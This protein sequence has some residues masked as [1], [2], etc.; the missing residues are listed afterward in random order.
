M[1]IQGCFEKI[2]HYAQVGW[3]A[4]GWAFDT[5]TAEAVRLVLVSDGQPVQAVVADRFRCDLRDAGFGQGSCAFELKLPE[6]LI[7][8]RPHHLEIYIVDENRPLPKSFAEPFFPAILQGKLEFLAE[9]E[10]RGWAVSALA[11]ARPPILDVLIDDQWVA[12]IACDQSR[13]DI[14]AQT[15]W[16]VGGGF[17]FYIPPEYHDDHQHTL[18]FRFANGGDIID[19]GQRSFNLPQRLQT[20]RQLFLHHAMEKS[21]RER[22]RLAQLLRREPRHWLRDQER[23]ASWRVMHETTL[24]VKITGIPRQGLQTLVSV[25][26]VDVSETAAV[27]SHWLAGSNADVVVFCGPYDR[28]HPG[29][30]RLLAARFDDPSIDA[31]TFDADT[32]MADGVHSAPHFKPAWDPD[33]HLAKNY[34]G[35]ACA[36]RRSALRDVVDAHGFDRPRGKAL[37]WA[38]RLLDTTLLEIDPSRVVHMPFVLF[39]QGIQH[40]FRL[41]LRAR[42]ARLTR[43][44]ATRNVDATVTRL[45]GGITHV[46]RYLPTPP[47]V[48][49]IIPT[50][51]RVDLLETCVSSL[52][53]QTQYPHFQILIVDNQ[54]ERPETRDYLEAVSAHDQVSVTSWPHAFNYAGLH[55]AV[56]AEIET[57]FIGL[58]NNDIEVIEGAWLSEMMSHAIRSEVAAVGAK[59]LFPEGLIQHGGVVIGQHGIADNAQRAFAKDEAGY[60]DSL[61][62]PQ[63]V[64]A[65][66]AACLICRRAD[67]LAVGGM[68]AENLPISF[69]DVDFCLK[70]KAQGKKIIWT[71][72]ATLIHHESATRGD[73]TTPAH[74]RREKREA[75]FLKKKWDTQNFDD[76]YYSPNLSRDLQT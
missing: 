9:A 43:H 34:V 68:D 15:S 66:T 14:L 73:Q 64:S 8:G 42:A 50:R 31:I 65:V 57:P 70:L 60:F 22:A 56:V 39:H 75:A 35:R 25:R 49:L 53:E 20:A 48:T 63:N 36:V 41:D 55:N 69:N 71:P 33:R 40:K 58:I 51:D 21:D 2:D 38:D 10:A 18:E 24:T 26:S 61:R 74:R 46:R 16:P 11:E 28:P 23:Y 27:L 3:F 54:S 1:P 7:D 29:L 44:L 30:A 4:K 47:A 19:A 59:L 32:L 76:P 37:A 62:V 72:Q 12:N 6:H 45:V 17:H 52:L 67:Y 5:T 13:P